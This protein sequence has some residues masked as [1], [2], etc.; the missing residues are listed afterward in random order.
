MGRASVVGT[1]ASEWLATYQQLKNRLKLLEAEFLAV[2][3]SAD[4]ELRRELGRVRAKTMR[5]EAESATYANETMMRLKEL[6]KGL[7][8]VESLVR[9]SSCTEVDS[10]LIQYIRPARF[11]WSGAE[12]KMSRSCRA[13]W[14]S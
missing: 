5:D 9:T 1:S 6:R 12:R 14:R 3:R 13:R 11:L 10:L 7:V 2:P 8:N 4:E